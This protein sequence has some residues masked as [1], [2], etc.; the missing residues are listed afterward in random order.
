MDGLKRGLQT[1]L[2]PVERFNLVNDTWATTLAGL[3][4]LTDYLDLLDLLAR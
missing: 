4:S 1:N 2:L 3:T